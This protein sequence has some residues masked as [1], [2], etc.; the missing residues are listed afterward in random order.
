MMKRE[1]REESVGVGEYKTIY[2][3]V[4]ANS[5]QSIFLTQMRIRE[6]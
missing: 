6:P 3:E 4:A 1:P 5:H 2:G